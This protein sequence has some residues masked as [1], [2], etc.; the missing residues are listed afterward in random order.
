DG[1]RMRVHPNARADGGVS[2]SSRVSQRLDMAARTM[3][4]A[5][6]TVIIAAGHGCRLFTVEQFDRRT[7]PRPLIILRP[8]CLHARRRVSRLQPALLHGVAVDAVAA[9]QVEHQVGRASDPAVH[10][11]AAFVTVQPDEI[12]RIMSRIGRN[13]LA[14][15]A[16]GRTETGILRFQ[17]DDVGTGFRRVKRSREA[18]EA[19]ADDQDIRPSVSLKSW[20]GWRRYRSMRPEDA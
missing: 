7:P 14:V 15:V 4:P 6:M 8:D 3:H 13:D 12:V 2:Q 16:A 11:L 1:R 18:G 19:A 17:Q 10:S 9:D 5:A 20:G